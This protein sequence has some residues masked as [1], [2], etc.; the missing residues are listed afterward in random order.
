LRKLSH[1]SIVSASIDSTAA[2]REEDAEVIKGF[3]ASPTEATPYFGAVEPKKNVG[4]IIEAYLSTT[5]KTPL[6]IV[7]GKAG[8]VRV[9]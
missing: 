2:H 7:G 4:R 3:S 8:R 6:V 1:L 9:S 5:T